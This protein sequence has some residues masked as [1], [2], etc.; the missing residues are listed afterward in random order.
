MHVRFLHPLADSDLEYWVKV[1]A[2]EVPGRRPA[3][4]PMPASAIGI[5]SAAIQIIDSARIELFDEHMRN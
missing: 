3:P 1:V 5:D 2:I 4:P